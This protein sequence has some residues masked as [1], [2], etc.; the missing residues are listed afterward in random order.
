VYETVNGYAPD[1]Q[2]RFYS[3]LAAEL[4]AR[5][6]ID[7]GCGTGLITRALAAE[8]YE[9]TGVDPSGG[10]LDVART[11]EHGDQVTWI[12]GDASTLGERNADLAIMSGH[13][14]QFFLTDEDWRAALSAVRAALRTGGALSFETRNPAAKEW[15]RWTRAASVIVDD[16]SAGLIEAWSEVV[17][18]DDGIVTYENHYKFGRT[19]DE[20]IAPGRLRFRTEAEITESLADAGFAIDQVYGDWDRGPAGA[21]ARELIV[22]ATA[23]P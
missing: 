13:V 11:G 12:D 10:M 2:P 17:E 4:G 18:V 6:I 1:T 9:M 19:R 3:E 20:L 21:A 23:A 7:L 15:E 16:P 22:V 5:R 14:A 8:G